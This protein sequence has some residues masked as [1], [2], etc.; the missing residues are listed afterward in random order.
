MSNPNPNASRMKSDLERLVAF[1]TENPPGNETEAAHF[2]SGLLGEADFSVS[3]DEYKPGRTNL[4]A[5]LDNGTGPSFA[6][7]THMDVVPA[8]EGWSSDPFVLRERDGRLYGRGACDAKGPLV[9][10]VEAMRLLKDQQSHWRGT[11]LGVFVADEEVASEG[12]KHFAGKRP[13]IDFAVI[14]E[15]TSNG[16]VIAHKGSMR[17]WVRVHGVSAHSGTPDLGENAIYQAARFVAM[18]EEHHRS[19]VRHRTHPLVGEASLTITRA[20]AGV[21]DNV[22]PDRCDLLLD[23]RTIPGEDEAVVRR[24][25]EGLVTA[26]HACGVRAEILEYKPTTGGATETAPNHPIVVASLAASRQHGA[27]ITA[28]QGFQGACDLVHFRSVGAQGTVIGPGS[29]AL[30]HKPDE[31]VPVDEFVASS[32]IYRD[33]AMQMLKAG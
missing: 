30:A 25:L 18:V 29:L 13:A 10:M 15:P 3:L 32:L 5:R 12:A 4:I 16:T 31:F 2:L 26:A 14:G 33:V 19:V 11:L 23:R 28:P 24:E 8:G 22:L 6:F 9:A 27:R 1:R 17:P 20:N 21:A 7:N